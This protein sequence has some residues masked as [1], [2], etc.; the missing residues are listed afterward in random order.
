[1]ILEALKSLYPNSSEKVLIAVKEDL[2]K[3]RG[4]QVSTV[5]LVDWMDKL[6]VA[7]TINEALKIEDDSKPTCVGNESSFVVLRKPRDSRVVQK[8]LTGETKSSKNDIIS[9]TCQSKLR[10]IFGGF[11]YEKCTHR[12]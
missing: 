4:K 1:M 2:E 9:S 3:L 6:V 11:I 8:R 7:H 12:Q 5:E 10:N